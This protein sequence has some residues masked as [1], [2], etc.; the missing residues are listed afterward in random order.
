MAATVAKPMW[1]GFGSVLR[2]KK[3]KA[4][5]AR[6]RQALVK[7]FD[8]PPGFSRPYRSSIRPAA[9]SSGILFLRST[10]GSQPVWHLVNRAQRP[11]VCHHCHGPAAQRSRG[12]T[13]GLDG[14]WFCDEY[15]VLFLKMQARHGRRAVCH[16]FIRP[17]QSLGR[18][19][20]GV[21]Q[22]QSSIAYAGRASEVPSPSNTIAKCQQG[23]GRGTGWKE[24]TNGVHPSIHSSRRIR[25][26]ERTTASATSSIHACIPSCPATPSQVTSTSSYQDTAMICNSQNS[27]QGTA[28]SDT[29]NASSFLKRINLIVYPR[30]GSQASKVCMYTLG[31]STLSAVVD[32][33]LVFIKR[34]RLPQPT[35]RC[36]PEWMFS[37][38]R[39]HLAPLAHR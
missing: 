33:R 39:A 17:R 37:C 4:F 16:T 38:E 36:I 15:C 18:V 12:Y 13:T 32:W 28:L 34:A 27:L 23:L 2:E 30:P 7:K 9:L 26:L 22:K 29:S 11:C 24:R 35:F 19:R 14:R 20:P 1:D 21:I 3:I 31:T 25:L 8:L 10:L 5:L 6:A